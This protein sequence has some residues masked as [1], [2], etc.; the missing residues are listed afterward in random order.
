RGTK[1]Y[2]EL[3]LLR[4]MQTVEVDCFDW[5]NESGVFDEM[6]INQDLQI[7]SAIYLEQGYIRVFIDKPSVKLIHNPEFTRINVD[8]SIAEG[9]QYFTN[10]VD[11]TGDLLLPRDELLALVGLKP[12]EPYN[13]L[14]QNR[15]AFALSEAYQEQGYAF[16]QVHPDVRINEEKRMVDIT[17]NITKGEKTYIGRIEFQGNRETRDYVLRREFLVR[18]NEL[19][20][21]RALRESQQ[22]L[23]ALG[24]FKPSMSIETDPQLVANE[25]DVISRV[26]ETQTGTLQ[27]Q[28]GYSDNSGILG[29]LSVSKGNFLGRGQTMRFSAQWAQKSVTREFSADFIEPHLLDT[30]FS[31][32]TSLSFRNLEDSA[33]TNRGMIRE[34]QGSQGTGYPLI[35]KFRLN[36]TLS[37]TNRM[38]TNATTPGVQLRSFTNGLNYNSVNHP[39]FP[40]DGSSAGISA[41]QV[42]GRVLGGT[43]EYRQYSLNFQTFRSLNR[44]N[45]LVVMGKFSSGWLEQ[46]GKNVI[47]LE[48]RFR[49]G[50]ISSLRGYDFGEIGGPFG[51]RDQKLHHVGFPKM[52]EMGQPVV[53]AKGNTVYNF[54]DSRVLGL[55]EADMAKLVGGGIQQRLFN[56]EMLF[57]LA[58]DNVRGV[59]FYDAGQ[60]NAEPEQYRLLGA[61]EPRFFDLL[62]A[63]GGGVRLIT[64]MGVFRFEYGYKL[65]PEQGESPDRFDFTI[66][67]LF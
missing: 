66:S 25:L 16:V 4:K 21:G 6:K 65:N 56:L 24:Y 2:S 59:V 57:P 13:P 44:D 34:I 41:S 7:L 47:P 42:G 12:R 49:M 63:V 37:A 54:V 33:E 11:V 14:Q 10:L 9:E 22:N 17:F 39:I 46:V 43:T 23:M 5:V 20:N 31:S 32:T 8:M 51:R 19:Y 60:V 18:E 27:A 30:N 38:F 3:A 45:T 62:Q 1:V 50:G 64:P 52:D 15:D 55:G 67:T 58:G 28:I 48:D 26:E 36:F 53:D 40:S 61:K 35:G 29:S